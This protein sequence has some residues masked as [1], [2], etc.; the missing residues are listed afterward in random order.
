MKIELK[1]YEKY[2]NRLSE[3]VEELEKNEISLEE[4]IKLY[5]E[6][7]EIYKQLKSIIDFEKGKIEIISQDISDNNGELNE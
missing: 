4:N 6:G 2:L 3:I 7:E 1:D 5:K